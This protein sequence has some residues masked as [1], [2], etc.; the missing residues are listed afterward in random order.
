MRPPPLFSMP[1][2][3]YGLQTRIRLQDC[4]EWF[5]GADFNQMAATAYIPIREG[6]LAKLRQKLTF[7]PN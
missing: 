6:V 4:P 2:S 3:G 1:P 5:E 7:T